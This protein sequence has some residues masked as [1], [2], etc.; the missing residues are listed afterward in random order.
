VWAL[1]LFT[2]QGFWMTFADIPGTLLLSIIIP[3]AVVFWWHA[4]AYGLPLILAKILSKRLRCRQT[5]DSRYNR[6]N[7]RSSKLWLKEIGCCVP[8]LHVL[9]VCFDI[10]RRLFCMLTTETQPFSPLEFSVLSAPKHPFKLDCVNLTP[11]TRWPRLKA[12]GPYL[13]HH[14][15]DLP[16]LFTH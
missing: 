9:F 10:P 7:S 14:V 13:F 15:C 2:V 8:C 12:A 11:R 6:K 3:G 16:V 4:S 5:L 1:I